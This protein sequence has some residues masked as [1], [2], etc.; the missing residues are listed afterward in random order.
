LDAPQLC[1][2][3]LHYEIFYDV[4]NAILREKQIKGG[5]R[6]KKIELINRMNIEWKDLYDDL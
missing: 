1:C 2:G 5:S 4:E 3:A 6:G